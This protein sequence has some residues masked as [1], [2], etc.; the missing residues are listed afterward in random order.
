MEAICVFPFTIFSNRFLTI[1][2]D[3]A[4]IVNVF[5]IKWAKIP[6]KSKAAMKELESGVHEDQETN[7]QNNIV[8]ED[9]K[10]FYKKRRYLFSRYDMGIKLDEESWYS[11][12]PE[13]LG[14]YVAEKVAARFPDQEINVIDA[15]AG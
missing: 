9:S 10:K 5:K 2:P 1:D 7:I 8:S 12:T 13:S 6:S 4:Q 11:V 14:E 3:G 15:F